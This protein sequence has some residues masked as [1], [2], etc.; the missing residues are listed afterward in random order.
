MEETLAQIDQWN[1]DK[2]FDPIGPALEKL[3]AE[4]PDDPE[5]IFRQVRHYYQLYVY[6]YFKRNECK[7]R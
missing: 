4:S 1:L 6:Y 7:C 2:N 5:V 3:L